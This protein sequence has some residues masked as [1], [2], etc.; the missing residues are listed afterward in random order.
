MKNSIIVLS[1]AAAAAVAAEPCSINVITGAMTSPAISLHLNAC[2]TDSGYDFTSITSG[3]VPT[4]VEAKKVTASLNCKALYATFQTAASSDNS[5]FDNSTITL[6]SAG[7][8]ASGPLSPSIFVPAT[9]TVTAAAA[10]PTGLA[11]S[12]LA[13]TAIAC[14]Q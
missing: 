1:F 10:S 8:D 5:T 4:E 2:K 13:F 11:L 12:A 6:P 14:L 7:S 9:K 3:K